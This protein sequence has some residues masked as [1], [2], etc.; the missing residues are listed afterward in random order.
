M[1]RLSQKS[2]QKG[3]LISSSNRLIYIRRACRDWPP[4]VSYRT[5]KLGNIKQSFRR[6]P[7]RLGST[8]LLCVQLLRLE[9]HHF[10]GTIGLILHRAVPWLRVKP[11]HSR[12]YGWD[13][14]RKREQ[15]ENPSLEVASLSWSPV[16]GDLQEVGKTTSMWVS[17]SSEWTVAKFEALTLKAH[18][19]SAKTLLSSSTTW[20][21]TL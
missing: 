4:I 18:S 5:F 13:E 3:K 12:L 14:E 9:S 20:L 7:F 2:H 10:K 15:I 16:F 8:A 17:V 6:F 19:Q 11:V 1:G 21:R